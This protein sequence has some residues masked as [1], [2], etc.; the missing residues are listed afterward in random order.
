M[1]SMPGPRAL[2]ASSTLRLALCVLCAAALSC[3]GSRVTAVN[4]PDL[5]DVS[6]AGGL[7]LDSA[8]SDQAAGVPAV[9]SISA[10]PLLE[11]AILQWCQTGATCDTFPKRLPIEPK[12]CAAKALSELSSGWAAAIKAGL[13]G[14]WPEAVDTC[15]ARLTEMNCGTHFQVALQGACGRLFV[16][17]TPPGATCND[18][19]QCT[20]AVCAQ[21]PPTCPKPANCVPWPKP[22]PGTCALDIDCSPADICLHKTCVPQTFAAVDE[23][24]EEYVGRRP[25][26][27][28]LFCHY[29]DVMKQSRCAPGVPPGGDCGVGMP[30]SA[31]ICGADAYCSPVQGS[32]LQ[33]LPRAKLNAKCGALTLWPAQPARSCEAGLACVPDEG[34]KGWPV[35]GICRPLRLLGEPCLG[36]AQCRGLDTWCKT[37]GASAEC[38][39]LPDSGEPCATDESCRWPLLCHVTNKTCAPNGGLTSGSK[40]QDN[41]QCATGLICDGSACRPPLLLGAPCKPTPAGE[42]GDCEP[43][44]VCHPSDL[45]CAAGCPG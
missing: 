35:P 38:A 37:T 30:E 40:C 24:C 9:P 1:S 14:T 23:L 3:D 36:D 32:T 8:L 21:E 12:A 13:V 11:M 6:D 33:C 4:T 29:N 39:L 45:H 16:G 41:K 26:Q 28:G 19:Y 2:T 27:L 7:E 42:Q 43:G 25:C 17:R 31:N 15:L 5:A 20:Q 22:Q 10:A 44:L 34:A 18:P